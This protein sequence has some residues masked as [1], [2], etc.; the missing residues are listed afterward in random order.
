MTHQLSPNPSMVR[1][2][3]KTLE[4]RVVIENKTVMETEKER[5]KFHKELGLIQQQVR[6]KEDGG[7]NR[8]SKKKTGTSCQEDKTL[9]CVTILVFSFRVSGVSVLPTRGE[10]WYGQFQTI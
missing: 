4:E 5:D 6:T 9:P 2:N 8:K 3:L 7:R 10:S 1:V